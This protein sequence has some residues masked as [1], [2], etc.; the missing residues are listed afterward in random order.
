ML[1]SVEGSLDRLQPPADRL[2]PNF[3]GFGF[4]HGK[5]SFEFLKRLSVRKKSARGGMGFTS[6]SPSERNAYSI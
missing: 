5:P 6:T 3:A 4:S 2:C 1:Y